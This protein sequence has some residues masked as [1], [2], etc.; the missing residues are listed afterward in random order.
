MSKGLLH[1]WG[2]RCRKH[3]SCTLG[4]VVM[5]LLGAFGGE[6]AFVQ[7]LGLDGKCSAGASSLFARAAALAR[8]RWPC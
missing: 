3:K 4:C 6:G 5:P 1:S 2:T 7:V 8:R